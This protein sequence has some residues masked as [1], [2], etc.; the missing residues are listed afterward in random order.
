[1]KNILV[2]SYSQSGQL[3]DIVA[4]LLRPL[5][6][7]G[8]KVH[9]EVLRPA[10]DF[11]FPWPFFAFL[12]AFPESV[13]L[14][15]RRNLPLSRQLSAVSGA[16]FDLVIL[17]WSVWYLSPAQ[18]ITAFLQSAEGK[19]LLAGRPVVSVVACRNMW[20]CA[21]DTFKTLV[22]E[23][24]G[25]LTD[26]VAFTDESHALATFITTPRWMFTGRRD[27]FLGLPPAGVDARQT[28]GA[29]RFG[30]A[31]AEALA[32]D[33]EKLDQPML[34]G[35]RAVKVAPH[36]VL[37]E[38]AGR[39]AFQ[40]WSGLIR[41]CGRAGQWRRIPALVLFLLYL[42]LLIVTVVPLNLILQ[43]LAAPLFARRI[44]ALARHYEQ[45]SGAGSAR[46]AATHD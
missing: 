4:A 7:F 5:V 20:L 22:A 42:V 30:A 35:L 44:T 41:A 11:P 8:V 36:L 26:H 45:P 27:R 38:R 14:D 19:Y 9:H 18:P 31:L 21:F 10:P 37:S 43:R 39:R 32:R 46:M 28:A 3:D 29:A 17:A 34:S 24:G 15:P 40:L 16:E 12:D 25:R 1:M 33:E 6:E 2:V 23:A 13:R